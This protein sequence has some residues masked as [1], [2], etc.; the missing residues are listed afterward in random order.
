MDEYLS[1]EFLKFVIPLIGA[2][3]A[4]FINEWRKRS[5]EEYQRKEERYRQL[6]LALKG[7]YEGQQDSKLKQEF[8]DQFNLCWLYCPDEVIKKGYVFLNSFITENKIDK[9]TALGEFIAEIRRDL[10]LRHVAR[11]TNL[12]G[13][14]YGHFRST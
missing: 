8:I 3:L 14:D 4:W 1:P 11:K 2:I 7:F 12:T 6:I 13:K 9:H 5:L 10:I